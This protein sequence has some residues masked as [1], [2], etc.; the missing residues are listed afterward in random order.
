MEK[1]EF[2]KTFKGG[3]R[4]DNMGAADEQQPFMLDSPDRPLP[5]F[6]NSSK[7]ASQNNLM[8]P[9]AI[10]ES[11]Q[12]RPLSSG[13]PKD[14]GKLDNSDKSQ[15]NKFTFDFDQQEKQEINVD[16]THDQNKQKEDP[17]Q[18]K[19]RIEAIKNQLKQQ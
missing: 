9:S 18:L 3:M 12:K 13:G 6:G 16:E 11:N 5:T 17:E 14:T 2:F 7:K 19:E 4:S 10:S 1:V 8:L 15:D